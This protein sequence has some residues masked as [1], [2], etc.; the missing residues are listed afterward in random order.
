MR[1]MAVVSV[2]ISA[3]SAIAIGMVILVMGGCNLSRLLN[4][5]KNDDNFLVQLSI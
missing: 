2:V 3:V 1:A 5:S 4:R